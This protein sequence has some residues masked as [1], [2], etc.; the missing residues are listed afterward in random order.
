MTYLFEDGKNGLIKF[1]YSPVVL[2][3]SFLLPGVV[4]AATFNVTNEAE[5]RVAVET[6]ATNGENNVIDLGG[7]TIT[8]TESEVFI[9]AG[10]EPATLTIRNGD[11]T[12]G[13]DAD[14]PFRLLNFGP[15][16]GAGFTSQAILENINFSNG[17]LDFLGEESNLLNQGGAAILFNNAGTI[18]IENSRFNNN[19]VQGNGSGGAIRI[20]GGLIFLRDSQFINN[21][22]GANTPETSASGGAIAFFPN[23]SPTSAQISGTLFEGNNSV[24]GG[25]LFFNINTS[26]WSISSSRF[27]GNVATTLGGAIF[28]DRFFSVP[29]VLQNSTLIGNSAGV[30]GG[31]YYDQSTAEIRLRHN[32]IIN[33]SADQGGGLQ[34]I[35]NNNMVQLFNNLILDNA[36]GNCDVLNGGGAALVPQAS[37]T[38]LITDATCV[39]DSTQILQNSNGVFTGSA[40]PLP[41]LTRAEQIDVNGPAFNTA[42][43]EECLRF[44]SIDQRR[45]GRP[46][47]GECDIGSYELQESEVDLDD[48]GIIGLMDNCPIDSNPDQ[49]NTDGDRDGDVCDLDDDNDGVL[50]VNDAFPLNANESADSDGDGVGDNLDNCRF[51]ANADQANNDGDDEGDVCDVDDDNDGV[52]DVDDAFPFDGTR[53]IVDTDLDEVGDDLDNCPVDANADQANNDG[54][55]EG[56]VCD[57]DDDNDGVLDVNDAF[58]FDDTRSIVDTDLD[59]VG[60]DLDNCPVDANAD[61]ANNDGDDEGDVCDVDDDNDGV[62]DVNDAFPFDDTRSIVDNRNLPVTVYRNVNFNGSALSVGEGEVTIGDLRNSA[63][64][65]DQLSSIEIAPGYEVVACVNSRLRGRCDVF[66]SSVTDLRTIGLNDT[67]SSLLVR[68]QSQQVTLYRNVNFSGSALSV[69]EGEVTIGDLRNSP[70]GN[71]QLSS[72][73]IPAGIEVVACTNSR[74][75]GRCEVF[76][77]SVSDLRTIGLNDTISSLLVR[78][79]PQQVTVYRNVNF[80]GSALSVGVGEVTIGDLRNSP[81]GND[82]LSS[83]AIPAGIEVVACVNSRLRGRCEVFTSSVSDLRTIGLNDTISSLDVRQSSQ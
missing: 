43:R 69:D 82:Q 41:S 33:N 52:L 75:R 13:V 32:T 76:T 78:P 60:D 48:D 53:S 4:S 21:S 16:P 80:S 56:D 27:E 61:Q 1:L 29:A 8:L 2:A 70:V 7:N 28:A 18:R 45:L 64:G 25:A 59:G 58:P 77:S 31:A 15:R 50:D 12:R 11:I 49:I 37:I 46:A 26:N 36:G 55:D 57:V 30:G 14:Q 19:Q 68:P 39:A 44:F 81:V 17:F 66:T 6:S 35:S 72:I 5:L 73:A 79:Q 40:G 54:D 3:F 63:V 47:L 20:N 22:A 38:N 42:N 62:L 67:I 83:I 34:V 23:I 9:P 24:R 71:D 10:P 65:N 74:L 51:D